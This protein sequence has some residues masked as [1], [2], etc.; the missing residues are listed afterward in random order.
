MTN[1]SRR[2]IL[3]RAAAGAAVAAALPLTATTASAA[4]VADPDAALFAIEAKFER[5]APRLTMLGK[6]FG[7]AEKVIFEWR[8]I[9][10][11]PKMREARPGCR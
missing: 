11:K 6:I 9:N 4:I 1:M 7:N 2:S 3:A 5:M 10:P 8:R